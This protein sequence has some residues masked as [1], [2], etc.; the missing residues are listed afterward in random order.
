MTPRLVSGLTYR[1]GV[2][3][4]T[5]PARRP[6]SPMPIRDVPLACLVTTREA[7]TEVLTSGRISETPNAAV[8]LKPAPGL[9]G[10]WEI[11]DGHHRVAQAMRDGTRT[12]RAELDDA[13]DD[14]PYEPP[15][16]DFGPRV[17]FA[18]PM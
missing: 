11:A 12:I 16:Y 15:F 9:P 3:E 4:V 5:Q 13:P 17:S 1:V 7:M 10:L 6:K 8:W 14:E 18:A 2:N